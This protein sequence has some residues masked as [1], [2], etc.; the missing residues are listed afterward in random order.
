MNSKSL[1]DISIS[2][3]LTYKIASKKEQISKYATA[4]KGKL[5]TKYNPYSI[6]NAICS[7]DDRE[8][9]KERN[10]WSK[11][12]LVVLILFLLLLI[13]SIGFYIR[14]NNS[15]L[16]YDP[17]YGIVFGVLGIIGCIIGHYYN[18]KTYIENSKYDENDTDIESL[19]NNKQEIKSLLNQISALKKD[20]FVLQRTLNY[21]NLKQKSIKLK[22]KSAQ[23]IQDYK[24][25]SKVQPIIQSQNDQSQ[26]LENT[27]ENVDNLNKELYSI[28]EESED[29]KIPLVRQNAQSNLFSGQE[30]SEDNKIPLVRQNAQSNLL[31]GQE[32]SEDNKIPLVRQNAQSNLLSNNKIDEIKE[33]INNK[34]LEL[35]SLNTNL[36]RLKKEYILLKEV[37]YTFNELQNYEIEINEIINS[38]LIDIINIQPELLNITGYNTKVSNYIESIINTFDK[39]KDKYQHLNQICNSNL[40]KFNDTEKKYIDNYTKFENDINTFNLI[41]KEI[42][43][44]MDPNNSDI[45]NNG[46][47]FMIKGY[48]NILQSKSFNMA[49]NKLFIEQILTKYNDYLNQNKP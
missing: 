1:A 36:V 17:I 9:A 22:D 48:I 3:I 38:S 7:V 28:S 47:D 24:N 10:K 27:A 34:Q 49:Y 42:T 31:S 19:K 13:F 14:Q 23:M 12:I 16:K 32:E 21:E 18:S 33:K 44:F 26:L 8:S 2:D 41:K 39:F 6:K 46:I 35:N 40:D 30:E 29:N 25:K 4:T 45:D 15:D 11:I 37:S 5:Y 20:I 43:Q